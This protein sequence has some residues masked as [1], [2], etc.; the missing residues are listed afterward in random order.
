M[1]RWIF[2][3]LQPQ[4]LNFL[5]QMCWDSDPLQPDQKVSVW[6]LDVLQNPDEG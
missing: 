4:V 5:P 1:L 3:D 6:L 2:L